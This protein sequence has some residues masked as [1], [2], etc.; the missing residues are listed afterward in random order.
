[1]RECGVYNEPLRPHQSTVWKSSMLGQM[2][3]TVLRSHERI[4][5]GSGN[6]HVSNNFIMD[7]NHKTL[8][9]S[10]LL[11]R[12]MTGI[13]TAA[14]AANLLGSRKAHA[15]RRTRAI[16]EPL[17]D[18]WSQLLTGSD[19]SWGSDVGG[20]VNATAAARWCAGGHTVLVVTG[21]RRTWRDGLSLSPG[22]QR[23]GSRVGLVSAHVGRWSGLRIV[24][25]VSLQVLGPNHCVNLEPSVLLVPLS[26][27]PWWLGVGGQEVLSL[28]LSD[29]DE[30]KLAWEFLF[31]NPDCELLV[32]FTR[33]DDAFPHHALEPLIQGVF[34]L[35]PERL[36]LGSD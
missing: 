11:L 26:A 35:F 4:I 8:V 23:L 34:V 30:V 19:G 33:V 3:E 7:L 28:L 9:K 14:S 18:F 2:G 29:G 15:S 12:I 36:G 16:L 27:N 32:S 6:I 1:M 25:Y 24:C 22:A 31:R 10:L 13:I 5:I 20:V 17:Q 21:M